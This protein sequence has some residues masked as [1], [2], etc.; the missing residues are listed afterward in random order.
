M[1]PFRSFKVPNEVLW[2]APSLGVPAIA[3]RCC[4]DDNALIR[5]PEEGVFTAG[6]LDGLD[7]AAASSSSSS[8]AGCSSRSCSAIE[9]AFLVF[10]RIFSSF[11]IRE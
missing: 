8:A 1:S 3:V 2:G 4:D 10:S 11:L 5:E 9:S 6:C 7:Y